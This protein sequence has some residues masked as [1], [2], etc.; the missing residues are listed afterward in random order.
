MLGPEQTLKRNLVAS[1]Q[2]QMIFNPVLNHGNRSDQAHQA[3]E[4]AAEQNQFWPFREHLFENQNALWGGDIQVALKT[5][6]ADFGLDTAAFDMCLDEQ[7]Y[8]DTVKAQ[9]QIRR[10]KGILSQPVFD[11]NGQIIVGSQSYDVFEQVITQQLNP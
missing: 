10:T 11:I 8:L 4:C 3:A 2:V 7:R 1:G 6:A 5:L 9:D